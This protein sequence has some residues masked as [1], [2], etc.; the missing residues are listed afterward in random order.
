LPAAH[1][2]QEADMLQN[3][4]RGAFQRQMRVA[5]EAF[6]HR[7]MVASEAFQLQKMVAL[8]AYQL[9]TQAAYRYL[10]DYL[11]VVVDMRDTLVVTAGLQDTEQMMPHLDK[12]AFVVVLTRGGQA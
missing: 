2:L 3:W 10:Q 12:E 1:Q 5:L 6:Q 11:R 7:M 8:E 9:G 4:V